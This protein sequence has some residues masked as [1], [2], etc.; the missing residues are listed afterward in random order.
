M[1]FMQGINRRWTWTSVDNK[2]VI[3]FGF[4][5]NEH[6]MSPLQIVVIGKKRRH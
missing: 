3:V 5:R 6:I 2:T 1:G 4:Q